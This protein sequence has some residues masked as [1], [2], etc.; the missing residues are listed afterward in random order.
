MAYQHFRRD[1][2]GPTLTPP[3]LS[4]LP[5]CFADVPIVAPCRTITGEIEG[6]GEGEE[7][8][9]FL[10]AVAV[11]GPPPFLDAVAA[12]V[13]AVGEPEDV[14]FFSFSVVNAPVGAFFVVAV[15]PKAMLGGDA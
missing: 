11:T 7:T 3:N 6:E 12:G 8:G 5:R 4:S 10:F 2:A 13:E 1:R 14:F 15:V 9:R